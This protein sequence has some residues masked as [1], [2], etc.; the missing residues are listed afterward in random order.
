MLKDRLTQW[1]QNRYAQPSAEHCGRDCNNNAYCNHDC[2]NCLKQVHWYPEYGG[3]SDYTC[4]NLLLKYVTRFTEKYSQQI[5]EALDFVDISQYPYFNILS[6]G[7]GATPDLMAFE[8]VVGNEKN[9]YYKG[10]DRNPLWRPIHE[11][12]EA[13]AEMTANI[14]ANLQCEDIF[15]VLSDESPA[16]TQYNVIVIQYLLSHLYNTRQDRQINTLFQG[17]IDNIISNHPH[18]SPFLII[19][20]DIDSCNK[21]RNTWYSFLDMLEDANYCGN[22]YARSA[23]PAGDLGAERWSDCRHKQSPFYG[24]ISYLYVQNESSHD[25]A[26]LVIELR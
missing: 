9:I 17:V 5:R 2:D 11:K 7:C 6:I 18:S 3:R 14:T 15:D 13:Y 8:E 19:I 12:I 1:C 22:A 24:N 25:G 26:Q 4:P 23:F 16:S 20:T 10:Y 21:G